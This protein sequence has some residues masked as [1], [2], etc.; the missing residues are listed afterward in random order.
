MIEGRDRVEIA[1]RVD[2]GAGVAVLVPR[3]AHL[4]V[5]LQHGVLDAGFGELCGDQ[6]AGH[7]GADDQCVHRRREIVG[8]RRQMCVPE[9][10]TDDL[11]HHRREFRGHL[12]ARGE[13]HQRCDECLVG[14]LP[15]RPATVI[16]VLEGVDDRRADLLLDVLSEPARGVVVHASAPRRAVP[17]GHPPVVTRH[18]H[19]DR[20]QGRDVARRHGCPDL[21]CGRSRLRTQRNRCHG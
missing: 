5:L 19:E 7:T 20:E 21:R 10:A 11:G 18:F 14:R 13:R 9:V 6:H 15:R 12:L 2:T 17:I 8:Q 4:V 16:P 1:R 3:A